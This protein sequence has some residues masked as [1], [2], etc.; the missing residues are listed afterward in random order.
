MH[1]TPHG[2]GTH[3]TVVGYT[4]I[5]SD[6]KQVRRGGR[7]SGRQH[8]I[9]NPHPQR[10][11]HGGAVGQ[12]RPSQVLL[13]PTPT[14][15]TIISAGL[16]CLSSISRARLVELKYFLPPRMQAHSYTCTE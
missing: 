5:G 6:F 4:F 11:T 2:S 15:W 10:P 9:T 8:S 14:R 16:H 12:N 1:H 3:T 7:G 13:N